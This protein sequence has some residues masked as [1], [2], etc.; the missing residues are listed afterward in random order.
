MLF[1][2]SLT[3][4]RYKEIRDFRNKSK[5]FTFVVSGDDLSLTTATEQLHQFTYQNVEKEALDNGLYRIKIKCPPDKVG[6]IRS[7]LSGLKI[8]EESNK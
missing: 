6:G 3:I 4:F 7:L 8:L 1:L 5:E 2:T